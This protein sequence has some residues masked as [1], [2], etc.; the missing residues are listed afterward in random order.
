MACAVPTSSVL[1]FQF[2]KCK[3]MDQKNI[4]KCVEHRITLNDIFEDEQPM[5]SDLRIECTVGTDICTQKE[6]F[7]VVST[8]S[9][10]DIKNNFGT[11]YINF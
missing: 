3:H 7:E 4:V 11:K 8:L 9:V 2:K 6:K 1:A 10:G 5:R